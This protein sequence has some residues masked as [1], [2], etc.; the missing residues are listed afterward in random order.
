MRAGCRGLRRRPAQL[1]G[2]HR[3][4]GLAAIR[5]SED[6]FRQFR[7]LR[8][9]LPYVEDVWLERSQRDPAAHQLRLSDPG[10]RRLGPRALRGPPRADRPALSR[11]ADRR[12]CDEPSHL[13]AGAA[14]GAC[15]RKLPGHG[16]GHRR[17]ELFRRLLE[18]GPPALRLAGDA[19]APG[20]A[21]HPG[22]A[23]RP[24]AGPGLRSAARRPPARLPGPVARERPHRRGRRAG[25]GRARRRL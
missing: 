17:P 20:G 15:R 23:S 16:L 18:P 24:G 2:R 12:A 1:H 9:A 13:P 11:R 22:P 5:R 10:L 21:R 19:P 4:H 3:G 14:P 25:R 6:L 8:Q 7:A